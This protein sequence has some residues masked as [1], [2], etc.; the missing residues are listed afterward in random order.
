MMYPQLYNYLD[1][2][3]SPATHADIT[4]SSIKQKMDYIEGVLLGLSHSVEITN[5]PHYYSYYES[6][7]A[8]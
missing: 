4:I 3:H 5:Y 6:M 2:R 8:I 1:L 7:R